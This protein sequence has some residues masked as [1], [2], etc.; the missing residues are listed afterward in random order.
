MK[1]YL[2]ILATLLWIA[3]DCTAQKVVHDKEKEKQWRSM[4]VGPWD[5]SPA[6][7]YYFLH[8]NYSG[9]EKYWK[10]AGFKSGYRVRF[11]E[12][13]SNVKRIMPVRVSA[14]A[15]QSEK[16]KK[17]EEERK[18]V[19][20][21]YDEDV[22]RQVDRSKDV[23]YSSYK[24]EFNNMQDDIEEGLVYCL[25][26]SKGR[27]A[28]QVKKLTKE[29]EIICEGIAYIHKEGVGYELENSKRQ[30]AYLEFKDRMRTLKARVA[31]LVAIAQTHY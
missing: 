12:S 31:N 15:V 17:V 30:K 24:D 5:F 22:Y 20:E 1:K 8:N 19:K 3:T 13:K 6:W 27:L 4:E 23:M 18:Y 11:K 2:F 29:D 9:A 14:E 16:V 26:K 10:W 21:L 25:A 28:P 7:Y